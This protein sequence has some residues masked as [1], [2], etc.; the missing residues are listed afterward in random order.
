MIDIKPSHVGQLHRDMHVAK[1]KKIS[2][3]ALMQK[4]S[5]DKASGNTTGLKRDVFAINARKFHHA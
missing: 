4:K 3:S 1:G 5:K 2:I